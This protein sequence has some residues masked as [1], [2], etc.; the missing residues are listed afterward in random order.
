M[1]A[2]IIRSSLFSGLASVSSYLLLVV[3]ARADSPQIFASFSY[4]VVCG[5]L[6]VL[7]IDC[8]A[9]QCAS[10]L[11]LTSGVSDV[12]AFRSIYAL[13]AILASVLFALVIAVN[14]AGTSVK[15]PYATLLFVV[16]AFYLGPLFELRGKNLQYAVLLATERLVLL[17]ACTAYVSLFR[18]DI[19]VYVIHLLV[20][21]ASLLIQ[22][23]LIG[24]TVGS[25]TGWRMGL[26]REYAIRYWPV[27]LSLF[28]QATYGHVSR[29]II[30]ARR[31]LLVFASVS[32]ALQTL[33]ALSIVQSQVDRH[34]RPAIN[35]A[36]A[37]RDL[38]EG[39]A[40]FIRYLCWYVAP[41][42]AAA[43][44]IAA[45]ADRLVVTLFGVRWA[46]VAG[47]MRTLAPLIVT[48]PLLRF[49]EM[50]VVAVH[51]QR[52]SLAIN[53]FVA[54]MLFA[55]LAVVSVD[56]P[57]PE[58]LFGIVVTQGLHVAII[59]VAVWGVLKRRGLMQIS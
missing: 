12:D 15:V 16:P 53:V 8:A 9:D 58:Y 10:Q 44:V 17:V 57:L 42:C 59:A 23:R 6:L 29:L 41:L 27:Y 48:V 35:R 37:V 32:L 36:A 21:C 30:E 55:W 14:L 1:F 46:A 39:K 22:F 31:G 18:F 11:M 40:L 19:G 56:R 3:L 50:A 25:V 52:V 54:G 49:L 47:P 51:A 2:S 13:K 45:S 5:L 38:R 20:S 33:N 7:A 24:A 26:A 43:I 4:A 28:A 34:F